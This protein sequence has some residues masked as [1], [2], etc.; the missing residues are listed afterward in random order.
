MAAKNVIVGGGPAGIYAIEEIRRLDPDA[1]IV[2]V[3]DE[4]AYARMALPYFV[5]GT[6]PE[7]QTLTGGP[8]YYQRMRVDARI[9]RR[10]VRLDPAART[11]RLDDGT[12]LSY[13]QLLL[14]TGSR[15]QRPP[16]PGAD[17][18]GVLPLWTLADAQA[19]LA[20]LPERGEVCLIGAGFIGFIILNALYKR[21]CRCHVVEIRPQVL[22]RMLD[23]DSAALVE[24]WLLE[25]GIGIHTG[26]QVEA[27]TQRDRRLAVKLASGEEIVVDLVVLATGVQPNT[28]LA[29]EAGIACDQGIL[30]DDHCRT[31][32]PR[33][34]AAGDCAQGPELI[35]GRREV[36]A[37]QPTAVDHGRVAGANMAGRDV[38]Y[39]GS[40][41]MNLLDV[42]GLHCVSFGQWAGDGKEQTRV[43]NDS[44]PGYRKI[45]WDGTQIVGAILVGP[46]DDTT[47]LNDV[48][49]LKGFIQ[50]KAALG[51]WKRYLEE[52]PTDLRRAYVGAGIPGRLIQQRTTGQ[53]ASD[54]GHRLG[55]LPPERPRSPFHEMLVAGKPEMPDAPPAAAG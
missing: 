18:P 41:L 30:I 19:A 1:E 44:L 45:V 54:R 42:C 32:D 9:G 36:H 51:P 52:N 46:P 15:A 22:P 33:V 49:M 53:P 28:E 24:R 20:R 4:P 5:A 35:T 23:R 55:D 48:G 37:I 26:A 12:A 17:L 21:G 43:V 11:L 13:D 38:A 34:F 27:I 16:I 3:S 50:S 7:E 14:A 2:L 8:A 40:L 10:A 47:M 6:A 39:P 29:R 31:S 25:R